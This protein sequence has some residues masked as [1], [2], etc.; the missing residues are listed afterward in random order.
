MAELV[1]TTKQNIGLDLKNIFM[2]GEHDQSSVVKESFTTAADGKHR[3]EVF[4][5]NNTAWLSQKQLADLYQ[6]RLNTLTWH[7][8]QNYSDGKLDMEATIRNYRI[9]QSEANREVSSLAEQKKTKEMKAIIS[10]LL[11]AL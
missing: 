5:E 10:E 4:I 2:E 7:I 11:G 8:A 1:A 6:V 3:L 9:V